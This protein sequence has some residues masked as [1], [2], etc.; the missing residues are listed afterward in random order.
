MNIFPE[1]SNCNRG[2]RPGSFPFRLRGRDYRLGPL[3]CYE[4]ILPFYVNRIVGRSHPE[5]LVNMTIDTWFGPTIEPWEHLALAQRERDV[6]DAVNRALA[7]EADVEVTD[8]DEVAHA[9]LGTF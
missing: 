7:G 6:V 2:E 9:A 3:I 8:I 4:D 5:L 1:A